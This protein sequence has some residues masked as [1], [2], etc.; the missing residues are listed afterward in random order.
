MLLCK[1][2]FLGTLVFN[3]LP[4][5]DHERLASQPTSSGLRRLNRGNCCTPKFSLPYFST[6][7]MWVQISGHSSVQSSSTFGSR[8][9]DKPTYIL[10]FK[11]IEQGRLLYPKIYSPIFLNTFQVRPSNCPRKSNGW[12]DKPSPKAV[13]LKLGFLFSSRCVNPKGLKFSPLT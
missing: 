11:K 1:C 5:S 10:R 9:E 8:K 2:K 13:Y 7:V 3:H 12:P 6:N 4:P